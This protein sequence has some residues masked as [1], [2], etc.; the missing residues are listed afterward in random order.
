MGVHAW[1]LF[2]ENL[3]S[4]FSL[5]N[6]L[7]LGMGHW[8]VE[9]EG[10]GG[11]WKEILEGVGVFLQVV[12]GG[13]CWWGGVLGMLVGLV[14]G[15]VV[16]GVVGILGGLVGIFLCSMI[17]GMI[18]GMFGGVLGWLVGD[19]VGEKVVAGGNGGGTKAVKRRDNGAHDMSIGGA[20]E[21]RERVRKSR[22]IGGEMGYEFNF[23]GSRKGAEELTFSQVLFPSSLLSEEEEEDIEPTEGSF[24]K[25]GKMMCWEGV[26]MVKDLCVGWGA[27]GSNQPW[28]V[29]LSSSSPSS[30]SPSSPSSPTQKEMNL[31]AYRDGNCDGLCSA[32]SQYEVE[33]LLPFSEF[34]KGGEGGEN[35]LPPTLFSSSKTKQFSILLEGEHDH[36]SMVPFPKTTNVQLSFFSDLFEILRSLS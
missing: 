34:K 8:G 17:F 9:E 22:E 32:F 24:V 33:N 30:P 35:P 26:L 21:W 16:G 25:W 10:W 3:N 29:S 23:V 15:G 19:W 14:M 7:D 13:V 36:F 4:F 27:R 31:K 1:E 12:A 6:G 5:K 2:S 18:F 28:S 11:W 20:E